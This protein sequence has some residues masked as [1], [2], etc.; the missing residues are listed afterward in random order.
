MKTKLLSGVLATALLTTGLFAYQ[1]NGDRNCQFSNDKKMYKKH[2]MRKSNYKKFGIMS[3]VKQLN[4]TADQKMKI[5]KVVRTNKG[6]MQT[7]NDAFTKKEFDKNKF[8][9]IL[10]SKR[11]NMIKLKAQMVAD[12]YDV[13]TNEQK[14]QFKVL[15]DLKTSKFKG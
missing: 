9:E 13:L 1:N 6:K 10:S 12:I 2:M 3:V 4:L 7:I 15:L 5:A 14:E 11:E 8:I